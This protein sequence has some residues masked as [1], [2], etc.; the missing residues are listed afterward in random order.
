MIRAPRAQSSARD[1]PSAGRKGAPIEERVPIERRISTGTSWAAD[2]LLL[3]DR[4]VRRMSRR[5][6]RTSA[7]LVRR[8]IATRR[9][10]GGK[11]G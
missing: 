11:A 7:A 4:V 2:R 5:Q 9:P 8:V 6:G 1:E 10:A 3:R